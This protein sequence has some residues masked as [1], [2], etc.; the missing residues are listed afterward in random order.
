MKRK[1]K[2]CNMQ[3]HRYFLTKPFLYLV[4]RYIKIFNKPFPKR[5]R[6]RNLG[7]EI[8]TQRSNLLSTVPPSCPY[9]PKRNR[10]CF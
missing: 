1:G 6:I 8:I 5:N 4:I 9:T 10:P 2:I 7:E 3:R